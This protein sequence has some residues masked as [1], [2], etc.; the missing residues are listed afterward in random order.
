MHF[1][2]LAGTYAFLSMVMM[3]WS[4]VIVG[5]GVI[6]GDVVGILGRDTRWQDRMGIAPLC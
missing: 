2:T 5:G 6:K 4:F 3:D 1:C